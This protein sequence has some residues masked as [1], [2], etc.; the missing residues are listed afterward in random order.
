MNIAFIPVRGGSKSIPLKNIKDFCGKPLV[1]WT[2]KAANNSSYVEKVIVS[3]DNDT[4]KDYVNSLQLKKVTVFDRCSENA[5]D[6]SSTESAIFEYLEQ[7]NIEE[8]EYLV[9]LQATSPFTSSQMLDE[10]F[11][12]CNTHQSV[13][14]GVNFK[15]FLW[16]KGGTPL[17]YDYNNR[18]RRQNFEGLFLENGAF[19]I[20]K[21][22]DILKSQ[23]RLSG[24]IGLFE[25][26]EYSAIEIDEPDDW[27][28]AEQL[29]KKHCLP[30]QDEVT[31]SIKLFLTDVDG[32]LTDTG[33]Y[34]TES[35]DEFKKFNT[36]DGMGF[37]LLRQAGIKTGIITS[38]NTQIV[39]RRAAKLKVDYI[40]QGKRDDGKL[41]A[42]KEICEREGFSLDQ[43]AYI[44]DDI[45]C[46]ELL[47]NVGIAACPN[48]AVSVVKRIPNIIQLSKCG[49]EG[50]LREFVELLLNQND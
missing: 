43:V 11:G 34:Y 23:N 29:F 2:I 31:K 49:G 32:V 47:K 20:S 42:A 40:Y 26:P 27:T 12:L 16:N 19:Y 13:L 21:A 7:T 17:N 22:K 3:T 28:I 39:A 15:R 46:L 45:N 8:L 44:G 38:E 4:I 6:H 48:N 41:G 1:Y 25:M 36:H 14:S 30:Q 37:E 35:G 33:M 10:A 5:Q 50:A 24:S 9:L 18:P